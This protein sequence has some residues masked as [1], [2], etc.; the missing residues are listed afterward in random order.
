MV[1]LAGPNPPKKLA[2]RYKRKITRGLLCLE[3]VFDWLEYK[4]KY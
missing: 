4:K 1:Y 2:I 3:G